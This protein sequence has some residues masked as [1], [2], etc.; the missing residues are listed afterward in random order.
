MYLQSSQK[1]NMPTERKNTYLE[2]TTSVKL[3]KN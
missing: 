2:I 3:G 1:E